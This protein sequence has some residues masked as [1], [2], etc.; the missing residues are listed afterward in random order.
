VTAFWTWT[1]A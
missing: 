1:N